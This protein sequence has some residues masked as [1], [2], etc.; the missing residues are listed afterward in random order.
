VH[1]PL[2]ELG[3]DERYSAKILQGLHLPQGLG[4]DVEHH[5]PQE[6]GL[7]E[8]PQLLQDLGLEEVLHPQ[9]QPDYP[10]VVGGSALQQHHPV[11]AV[12]KIWL[13]LD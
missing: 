8:L 9:A 7:D 4:Q 13:V 10:A 1:Q 3:L 6:P 2:W 5:L 11:F 12:T